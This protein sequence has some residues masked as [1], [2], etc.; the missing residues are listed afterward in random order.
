MNITQ[1]MVAKVATLARLELTPEELVSAQGNLSNILGFVEQ[2]NA[3][4]L[5]A[6][7][8]TPQNTPQAN[9]SSPV[10]PTV[11]GLGVASF[12]ADEPLQ[13]IAL[14]GLL[15]NAPQRED[16]AFVVPNIL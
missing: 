2:M 6:L 8:D 16:T 12:R 11:E 1:E 15:Q 14:E 10:V 4:P 7:D 3:L 5:E 13:P 9:T